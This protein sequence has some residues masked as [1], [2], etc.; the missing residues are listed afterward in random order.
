[1]KEYEEYEEDKKDL[2][3]AILEAICK[4]SEP[5]KVSAAQVEKI[6]DETK[7]F[8]HELAFLSLPLNITR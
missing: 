8:L 6:L 7:N 3:I 5:N 1:M 2:Y 4:D